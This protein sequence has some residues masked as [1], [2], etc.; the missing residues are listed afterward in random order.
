MALLAGGRIPA[1][2]ND[3]IQ[4]AIAIGNIFQQMTDCA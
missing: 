3:V 2:E 4:E 1:A